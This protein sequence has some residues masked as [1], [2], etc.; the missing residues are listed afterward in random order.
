[1]QMFTWLFWYIENSLFCSVLDNIDVILFTGDYCESKTSLCSIEYN[2]C[3][4]GAKCIDKSNH[5][6]CEC[7]PG[8]KGENCTEDID[9]CIGNMCQVCENIN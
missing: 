5:Y 7:A 2:P 4:N 6:A 9:N 1:M 3:R 8:Y